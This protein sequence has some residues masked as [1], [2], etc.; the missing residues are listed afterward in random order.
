[1]TLSAP[2]KRTG[3]LHRLYARFLMLADHRHAVKIMAASSFAESSFFPI[4]PDVMLVPMMLARPH[5]AWHYALICTI[6]SVLGAV[7]GYWIGAG[8]YE[9]VGQAIIKAYHLEAMMDRYREGF[10]T[11]GMWIILAKGL[12]PIPFK[13]V[14]IASGVAGLSWGPFLVSCLITR[15]FRFF[16]LAA[17]LRFFG[18]RARVFIDRHLHVITWGF[19]A[20][21]IVGIILAVKI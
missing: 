15:A 2:E 6:A 3:F 11:W 7:L 13:L 10:A 1:M 12:T 19:L 9:T 16:L 18:E 5:K 4:P 20:V 21:F 17:L 14:T 8:L